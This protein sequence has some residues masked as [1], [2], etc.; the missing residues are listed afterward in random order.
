M[1]RWIPEKKWL[2]EEVFIIG[3]GKSLEHFN[4]ELL[5][6]E[7]T[8]GCNDAYKFGV[9]ICK[10]MIFGDHKWFNHHEA[11]LADYKGIVFTNCNQLMKSSIPWLWSCQRKLKGLY[12]DALGWNNNTGA[13]AINLA[14]LLGAS[15]IFLLGYDMKLSQG[16]N[17]WHPNVLDKP[18]PGIYDKF[19]EGFGWVAADLSKKFPNAEVINVT[20][21]SALEV[22]P[23]IS[24]AEFFRE[25][26]NNETI[27]VYIDNAPCSDDESVDSDGLYRR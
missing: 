27:D 17:N 24:V 26:T 14:L 10:V 9:D 5:R 19:Q 22:F 18:N 8:I 15:K 20:D 12:H 21:C 4:F 25:R 11:E 13:S 16:K 23:K 2:G 3:G 7:Y 1:P 6:N